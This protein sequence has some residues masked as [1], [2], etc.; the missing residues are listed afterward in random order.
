[1]HF[2]KI[3]NQNI[4]QLRGQ[5]VSII[6]GGGKST[7]IKKLSSELV[8]QKLK[9]IVTTT[10]KIQLLSKMGLVLTKNNPNFVSEL[11][12]IIDELNIVQVAK[13]Y[14]KK[15]TLNGI[16]RAL[17]NELSNYADVV[18]I[19]ADG[20]RQRSLK[21]HK[22]YEPVIPTCTSTVV[23]LCGANI[24]GEQLNESTV[25]RAELFSQ[26]WRHPFGTILTPEIISKEL[27]SP[28]SYLRNAPIQAQIVY[29]INK[30]DT[31]AI[32]GKLLAEHLK[33]TS[34]HRVFKASIK[35]NS[36]KEIK[37]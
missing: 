23:V 18:L 37:F 16:N 14:Y 4:D 28:H 19:E 5:T 6:G 20:S 27:L 11:K 9:V 31:N 34:H 26:K 12:V 22:E 13:E 33:R 7:L 17:V 10:T 30:I 29:L 21:T 1:M 3:I 36:L 15:D 8:E 35:K 24:V 25:H 32:G 2:Y